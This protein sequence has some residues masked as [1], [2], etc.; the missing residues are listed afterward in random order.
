AAAILAGVA[1][2]RLL[3]LTHPDMQLFIERKAS[4]PDRWAKGMRRLW[5]R[6]QDLF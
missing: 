3:I 2:E 6:A 4:D 5:A 1:D